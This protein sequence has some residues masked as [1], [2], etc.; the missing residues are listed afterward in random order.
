[1]SASCVI[2]LKIYVHTFREESQHEDGQMSVYRRKAKDGKLYKYWWYKFRWKGELIQESTKQSNKRIA[3]Q[4]EAAHRTKLAKGEVGIREVKPA[5]TLRTFATVDFL[6]YE[7]ARAADRPK[8][9]AYYEY[10]VQKLLAYAPIAD[11]AVDSL[12]SD[13]I[14]EFAAK[15]RNE[16]R[17]IS[18]VN[19]MLEVLRRML[20]LAVEWGKL[21]RIPPKVRMLPGERRRER[22]LT[23]DEETRYSAAAEAIGRKI[24]GDYGNALQGTRATLRGQEPKEPADPFLLRD[25]T[26]LLMDAGLRPEECF[27]LKWSDVRDDNAH[28]PF[29]K[30]ANARRVIPLTPRVV[31]FFKLRRLTAKTEWVFPAETKSG[32]IEPSSLK[33]QHPKAYRLAG[34]EPFTLY[35]F[36]HTCVTR[37]AKSVDPYTLKYLAGHSDFSTTSRYVH[38]QADTIRR[39]WERAHEDSGGY[40]TGCSDPERGQ[41]V[42]VGSADK[43]KDLNDLDGAP[44]GTRTPGLLV[45]SQSLYP[46]ELRARRWTITAS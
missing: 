41:A 24:L 16:G 6:P 19:K 25:A 13:R 45:R 15:H 29:G 34:I 37:W 27:G 44:G 28:I 9:L 39:Q 17:E 4:M 1:L 10:G 46:A 22:V 18:T 5:P 11:C 14:T 7:R 38:P 30:T 8:T 43:A 31:T 26:A 3:E 36:R 33:K 42:A 20:T 12:T 2:G 23:A 40:Q 21:N 32:H 35:T